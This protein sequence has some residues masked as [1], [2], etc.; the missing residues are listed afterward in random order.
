[1]WV[2]IPS[3]QSKYVS[4]PIIDAYLRIKK[5]YADEQVIEIDIVRKKLIV[6]IEI[7]SSYADRLIEC[8]LPMETITLYGVHNPPEEI[9]NIQVQPWEVYESFD[10]IFPEW[11]MVDLHNANGTISEAIY[12]YLKN[13]TDFLGIDISAWDDQPPM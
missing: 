3:Y 7:F 8:T 11:T 12:A 2:K 13:R 6:P 4:S 10:V 9:P 1:M 5:N